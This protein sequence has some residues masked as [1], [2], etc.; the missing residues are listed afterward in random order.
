MIIK[1][2]KRPDRVHDFDGRQEWGFIVR[3]Y[4]QSGSEET[5]IE[6]QLVQTE[7]LPFIHNKEK[8]DIFWKE[9]LDACV[10]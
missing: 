7:K 6:V 5:L 8:I 10:L 2:Y 1:D 3:F 9:K 4:E